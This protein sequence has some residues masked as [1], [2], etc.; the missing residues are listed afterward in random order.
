[1]TNL[2]DIG[3]SLKICTWSPHVFFDFCLDHL[4]AFL[5]ILTFFLLRILAAIHNLTDFCNDKTRSHWPAQTPKKLK[6]KHPWLLKYSKS[7]RH[8]Q[9]PQD[10]FKTGGRGRYF[11]WAPTKIYSGNCTQNIIIWSKCHLHRSDIDIF[12]GE[13]VVARW[14][15]R[16]ASA[17]DNQGDRGEEKGEDDEGVGVVEKIGA[18]GHPELYWAPLQWGRPSP[19]ISQLTPSRVRKLDQKE[20]SLSSIELRN[21]QVEKFNQEYWGCP[22]YEILSLRKKKNDLRIYPLQIFSAPPF[23]ALLKHFLIELTSWR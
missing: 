10:P 16:G 3:C 6:T 18:T 12:N 7:S 5:P 15:C 14:W 8:H 13:K 21:E 23:L 4:F 17:K 1:M 9:D 11:T 2:S 22:Y 20:L 19:Q